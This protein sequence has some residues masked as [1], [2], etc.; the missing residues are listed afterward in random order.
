MPPFYVSTKH[1]LQFKITIAE[2]L[3]LIGINNPVKGLKKQKKHPKTLP[4]TVNYSP[5]KEPTT[6]G[7]CNQ[8]T[9]GQRG[10]HK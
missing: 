2:F 1:L 10:G 6:K 8:N 9:D 5:Q 3:V 7:K 4:P